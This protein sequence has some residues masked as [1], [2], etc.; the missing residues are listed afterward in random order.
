MA[1][2]SNIMLV[3]ENTLDV[4]LIALGRELEAA[5]EHERECQSKPCDKGENYAAFDAAIDEVLGIIARISR[6][7][8]TDNGWPQSKK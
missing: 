6:Q 4:K 7:Q 2:E 3:F 5:I 8:V 1:T